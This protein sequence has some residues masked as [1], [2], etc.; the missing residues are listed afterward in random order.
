[1]KRM[2]S[3]FKIPAISNNSRVARLWTFFAFSGT[4]PLAMTVAGE[5]MGNRGN[6]LFMPKVGRGQVVSSWEI[7]KARGN[8]ILLLSPITY[9]T[10]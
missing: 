6:F 4:D 3:K 7:H 10:V 9:L 8:V 1:M 5:I 2:K